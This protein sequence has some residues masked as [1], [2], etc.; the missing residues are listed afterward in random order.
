[1]PQWTVYS[2]PGCGLCEELINELAATLGT[3]QAARVLVIDVDSDVESKRKYGHRVPVLLADGEFVCAY[4]LE[5]DRVL[6]HLERP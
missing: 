1:M 4:R 5:R 3:D 6:G 2:R